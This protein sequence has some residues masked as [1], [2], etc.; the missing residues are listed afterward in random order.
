MLNRRLGVA[1]LVFTIIGVVLLLRTTGI[2]VS[3]TH[4][5]PSLLIILGIS[6]ILFKFFFVKSRKISIALG[7]VLCFWGVML[8][9]SNV[10]GPSLSLGRIWPI[11]PMG[12]G[13]VLFFYGYGRKPSRYYSFSIP[14]I[15]I[16]FMSVFFMLFS[17]DVIKDDFKL[18]VIRWWPVLFITLG[19]SLFVLSVFDRGDKRPDDK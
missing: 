15:A 12:V 9:L 18:F 10:I 19:I 11:F 1:G 5:W 2:V 13:I 16:F 6:S 14:G 4:L 3:M 8:I 7:I 17:L